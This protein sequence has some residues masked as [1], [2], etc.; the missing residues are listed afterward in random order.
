LVPPEASETV[1]CGPAKV[2]S[3]GVKRV[4]HHSRLIT[5]TRRKLS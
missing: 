4:R 5:R 3:R 2:P 1:A